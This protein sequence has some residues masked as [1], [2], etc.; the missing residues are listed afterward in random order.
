MK[1]I[2]IL[3]F[4]ADPTAQR[5]S[6]SAIQQAINTAQRNDVIVI[7]QGHF[8]TGALFLKSGVSLR[9]DAG[10][11]LMGSQ[12]LADYPL[13]DTRVAGIEMRWPAGIINIINCENV[14]ITGTGTIDGQGAVWWQRFWGEDEHSGMVGDYS[15]RGLRWVV[16]YDCQRPRNV[17]VYESQ[18]ILLRDFTSRES[19][20][21]NMHLC[22]SRHIAVEGVQI[23]NS[24]G[25]STDGID[26][27]SCEQVRV[28]GC[29]V[30]CND[31]N[32][33]IKSGRGREAAQKARPARDIVIRG[34]TL[35]KGSGI[36][37]GSETSGGIERVLIEDNAFNGTGVGFR[38]KS[39]RNRG[40]F[41]RD[42]TVQNLRL[43]DV[44]FPVLIQLNWFPQ[45]S[46]GD[47]GNLS[48]KPEHWRKLA[49]GVEGEA[50][51]TAVSRLTLKNIVTRRSANTIFSRAFFIEGYPERPVSGLVL[52]DIAID[53]T[54]FGKISGVDGLHFNDV[55]VTAREATRDSNDVYER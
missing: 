23:S 38:I 49:E 22:Y 44:R 1:A 53:A 34:C 27:D 9:L 4:G 37:L 6:T 28:E 40:G 46:Y 19:G 2:S 21:W 35:N 25:P 24:A 3:A 16:D 7:P 14:S 8:L 47:Q 31:D 36:T 43:T 12:D 51:L 45:Y 10:A 33:C 52:E 32:I 54:E 41:I 15:A 11:R 42:I 50:G 55:H 29:I 17:L 20:F 18:T 30:S 26:I 13:I 5:L 39:A 48:E